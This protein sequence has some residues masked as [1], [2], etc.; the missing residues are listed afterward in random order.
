MLTTYQRLTLAGG[1][2]GAFGA[3]EEGD[4][5]YKASEFQSLQ[6]G[7]NINTALASGERGAIEE[8][9]QADLVKSRII[10]VAAASGASAS[11]PGVINL[12]ARQEGYGALKAGMAL[13]RGQE[14]ARQQQ[15]RADA[16]EY[17]G[18][19]ARRQSRISAISSMFMAGASAWGK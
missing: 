1:A 10:S 8:K 5:A 3:L 18:R 4:A 13:Y 16:A 11:D 7:M 19:M 15:M 14:E 12:V 6:A 9:R 2:M 17:E